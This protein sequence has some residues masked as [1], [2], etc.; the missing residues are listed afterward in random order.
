VKGL[1]TYVK[2]LEDEVKRRFVGNEEAVH[3]LTLNLLHERST[4][5]IRAP[6][7]RGKSTLM[8][9]FLKGIF[10]DDF[11]V[12]SGASEIKRGEVIARLHIPS[13]EKEG[14]E[15]V[16]WSAFVKAPGKGIDE[17]KPLHCIKHLP[18][19]PVRGG[20]GV[21]AALHRGGLRALR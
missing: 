21:W 3:V 9:L 4:A 18:P 14:V 20:V 5:L 2:R 15:R 8:L 13:L 1:K 12:I 19:P 6:R 11:V 7:G 17:V 16:I 10:G